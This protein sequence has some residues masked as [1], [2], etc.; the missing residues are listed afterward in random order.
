MLEAGKLR[1]RF[2]VQ[3]RT[4]VRDPVTGETVVAWSTAHQNVPGSYEP[5]SARELI[6]SQAQQS[7]VTARVVMR[8]LDGLTA[9][10]RLLH[11]CCGGGVLNIEG[12]VP[13][14]D[15]GVEWVTLPVS[16]GVSDGE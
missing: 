2:T 1:H 7:S 12:L 9:Q 8:K 3:A 4:N 15:S 5:L 14:P 6:A 13:D 11:V 10:H 16:V